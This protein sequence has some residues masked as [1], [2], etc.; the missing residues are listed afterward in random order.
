MVEGSDEPILTGFGRGAD[1]YVEAVMFESDRPL[2]FTEIAA[3][4]VGKGREIDTRRAHNAAAEIGFHYGR[5]I[6]GLMKH[7]PLDEEETQEIIAD[8]EDIIASGPKGRQ[9]HCSELHEILCEHGLD[10]DG[11]LTPYVIN[12]G[13]KRSK[14]LVDL[15]ATRLGR[16][17]NSEEDDGG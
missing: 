5:G 6:Y 9:W 7:Y 12:I 1:H 14:T 8:V 11:R 17:K 2:H 16:R 3:R 13:L 10:M 4:I 15:E